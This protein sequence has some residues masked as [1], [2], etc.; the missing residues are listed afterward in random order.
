ML[1][2]NVKNDWPISRRSGILKK[3]ERKSVE[4]SEKTE[5]IV[6]KIV[7]EDPKEK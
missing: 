6:K 3:S 2:R 1:D 5:P 4:L 7:K